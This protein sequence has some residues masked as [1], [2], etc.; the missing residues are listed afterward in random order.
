MYLKAIKAR[1]GF[2]MGEFSKWMAV[3]AAERTAYGQPSELKSKA[4]FVKVCRTLHEKG[5]APEGWYKKL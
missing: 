4:N 3:R 1:L 2:D 5:I